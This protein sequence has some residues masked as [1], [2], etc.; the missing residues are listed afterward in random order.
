[1]KYSMTITFSDEL[2][3]LVARTFSRWVTPPSPED[4]ST[5]TPPDVTASDPAMRCLDD[6]ERRKLWR[7]LEEEFDPVEAESRRD[8]KTNV[9]EEKREETVTHVVRARKVHVRKTYDPDEKREAIRL[10]LVEGWEYK[11]I[12]EL[13]GVNKSSVAMWV[14]RLRRG[15]TIS[16]GRRTD[17]QAHTLRRADFD[18]FTSVR[19]QVRSGATPGA[20]LA[21][22]RS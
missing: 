18:V 8:L 22:E 19:D 11:D 9:V 10:R 4:T 21:S 14:S 7:L 3:E 15:E 1:V 5:P 20:G 2:V 12:E 6:D 16:L 17:K 13:T